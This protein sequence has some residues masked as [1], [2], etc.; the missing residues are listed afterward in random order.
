MQ[1]GK[2]LGLMRE[3]FGDSPAL[4]RNKN[5][6]NEQVSKSLPIEPKR[7][8]WK[9]TEDGKSLIRSYSFKE[10]RSFVNFINDLLQMQNEMKHHGQIL[11]LEK[12]VRVKVST[13]S[14]QRITELDTEYAAQLDMIYKDSQ[15]PAAEQDE[16]Q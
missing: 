11:I 5:L 14:L 12:E 2:V 15:T 7:S 10:F 8:D 3:Y 1:S 13:E 6:I 16:F 4:P 9:I